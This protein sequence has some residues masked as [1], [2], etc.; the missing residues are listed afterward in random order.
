MVPDRLGTFLTLFLTLSEMFTAAAA[1]V[2]PR[3]AGVC[4]VA[5][6]E[7]HGPL[8]SKKNITRICYFVIGERAWE[9]SSLA[10]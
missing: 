2:A 3:R 9:N 1:A 10:P 8:G 7:K 5:Y 4:V 6:R